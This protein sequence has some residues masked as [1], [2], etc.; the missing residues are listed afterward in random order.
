MWP[1][2]SGSPATGLCLSVKGSIS[3]SP[4]PSRGC[5]SWPTTIDSPAPNVPGFWGTALG[6]FITNAWFLS[7]GALLLLGSKVTQEPKDFATAIALTAG[8]IALLILLADETH[9]A[10][11]D[12]YSCAVSVQ[13]LFPKLKQRWIIVAL[14]GAC[15]LAAVLLDITRFQNFLYF[16]GSF[17]AALRDA[18][19]GF[20][21]PS[22]RRYQVEEFYRAKGAYWYTRGVSIPALVAWIAGMAAYHLANP[23]TLGAIFPHG[24]RLCRRPWVSRADRRRVFWWPS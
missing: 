3:S 1:L 22:E 23:S 18:Q 13:N 7:L 9:N 11:A 6:F 15:F 2:F 4:F 17:C 5:L 12:L 8:W 19:R 10:W 14:G 16:V 20:L 24:R 21:R